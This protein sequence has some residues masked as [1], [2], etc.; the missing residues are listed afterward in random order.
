VSIGHISYLALVA[1]VAYFGRGDVDQAIAVVA[2]AA[3]NLGA[4]PFGRDVI[5]ELLRLVPAERAGYFEYGLDD[6]DADPV[7]R[8][9]RNRRHRY[10]IDEPQYDFGWDRGNDTIRAA[11]PTWPLHDIRSRNATTA[12]KVS[13]A[14]TGPHLRRN[15]WYASV[16]RPRSIEHEMKLWL[17]SPHDQVRGFY[18]VRGPR[19]RDFGERERALLDLLRPHFASIRER[20]ERR[21]QPMMLTPRELEVVRLVAVGLT[22]RE[23]ADRLVVSNA[24]VR[25]HLENVFEKLGVHTRTA[26][27][28]R[29]FGGPTQN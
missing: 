10:V 3:A 1:S 28:A 27:V 13:D 4:E 17:P 2:E 11:L 15:L 16:M 5:R 21:Q 8:W 14:L 22:N 24:T 9:R 19:D 18:F 23:I 26:A 29:A 7:V 20:W 12:S 6:P 25:T